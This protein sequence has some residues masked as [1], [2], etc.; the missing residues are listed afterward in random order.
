MRFGI[1]LAIAMMLATAV[2][3]QGQE[4]T[5]IERLFD[6]PS[7]VMVEGRRYG[8]SK[9]AHFGDS[10]QSAIK[11]LVTH[12]D[13]EG[14]LVFRDYVQIWNYESVGNDIE[15]V[16]KIES[17]ITDTVDSMIRKRGSFIPDHP[18]TVSVFFADMNMGRISSGPDSSWTT[19]QACGGTCVEQTGRVD[20]HNGIQ[21]SA[22][23]YTFINI[24]LQF[25]TSTIQDND[26][27][28]DVTLTLF[29]PG[30]HLGNNSSLTLEA[31]A[32]NWGS[33]VTTADW[34]DLS[35]A[36]NWT[37][38]PLLAWIPKP[39]TAGAE[40]IIELNSTS[41]FLSE[42]NTTGPTSMV[43][44]LNAEYSVNPLPLQS[45]TVFYNWSHASIPT[46][47]RPRLTVTHCF[48]SPCVPPT[49]TPTPTPIPPTE[50]VLSP[51]DMTVFLW[52][53]GFLAGLVF[54]GYGERS[55]Q[56][57]YI[58]VGAFLLIA[59][60]LGMGIVLI[61]VLS[62]AAFIPLAYRGYLLIAEQTN[63]GGRFE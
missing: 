58:F 26:T 54:I 51:A 9:A 1:V 33:T 55:R 10:G 7:T 42:I 24:Y 2:T 6:S 3:V 13:R 21:V 59:S 57:T 30:F 4:S 28:E 15:D 17:V 53:I 36:T 61:T 19:V 45:Q 43:T 12:N 23:N 25:D 40:T 31:R 38:L 16:L 34:I 11:F 50:I 35:V 63:T 20:S 8:L 48:M 29:S 46:N 37:N 41:T 27:I 60:S 5:G 49:P 18:G 47:E 62:A 39:T 56:G 22:S 14:N 32:F 44:L 52:V